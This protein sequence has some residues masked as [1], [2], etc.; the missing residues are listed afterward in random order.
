MKG[1][2]VLAAVLCAAIVF[3]SESFSID[4]RASEP[5]N[6]EFVMQTLEEEENLNAEEVSGEE[7]VEEPTIQPT[8]D[9]TPD[10]MEGT[11]ETVSPTPAAAPDN[12]E[13]PSPLETPD[14]IPVP[15]STT[16][17]AE[18]ETPS[19]LPTPEESVAPSATP[20]VTPEIAEQ[21]D[22]EF[23]RGSEDFLEVDQDGVLR[24]IDGK[25]IYGASVR[26]PKDAK[27]IPVGIFNEKTSVKYITFETGSELEEIEAGAFEGCGISSIE[28]P[29]GITTIADAT[30]KNSYLQSITFSGK[31]TCIGKEAFS[32][33]MLASVSA[34]EVTEVGDSAFSNC[35][36]L[37]SVQMPKLQKIGPRAFQYCTKLNSGMDWD[38]AL[39]EIGK[40]AFKGSGLVEL[41]LSSLGAE[42]IVL[43]ARAFENCIR[44][45]TVVL[46]KNLASVST[47]L[48]KG[49][50]ALKN[51]TFQK[52]GITSKV[53]VIGEDAFGDCS[54]LQRIIIPES[55]QKIQARAFEGCEALTEIIIR[56]T[57]PSEDSFSI[58][59]S[60][61]PNKSDNSKVTMQGYDGKVQE[62][63]E[64]RG[65]RFESLFEKY[66]VL[67]YRDDNASVVANKSK[68]AAGE[69]VLVTVTVKSG[70]S[71]TG[72]GVTVTSKVDMITA[73][74]V[75]SSG[76]KN[77]FRFTMPNG[78]ATIS[79]HTVETKNATSGA[80][81]FEFKAYNGSMALYDAEQKMLTFDKTG[82]ETALVVKLKEET[83]GSWLLN[84]KSNNTNVAT[85]SDKG[86]I[87][88]KGKGSAIITATLKNDSKKQISFKVTVKEDAVIRQLTLNLGKPYRAT[89]KTET[90][91][92][93]NGNEIT[94]PVVEYNKATVASEAKSFQV[95]VKAMEA[96]SSVDLQVNATWKSVDSKIASVSSAKTSDN[97][98]TVTVK[99]GMEGETMVTVSVQNKDVNKTECS[100]SFIIRVVDATPRLADSK[101]SVNKQSTEGTKIDI[102]PVYGYK[103]N[104]GSLLRVCKKVVSS[105]IVSYVPMNEFTVTED[106]G[107]FRIKTTSDMQLGAGKTVTYKGKTQLY[108]Q[109]EFDGTGDTF[110]IPIPEM[111]VVNKALNPSLKVTGKIN[112]FYNNKATVTEQGSVTITQNL[113]N[114][115]VSSYKLVS[116]KNYKTPG[117]EAEDSFAANFDVSKQA[118]GSALI[119]R[120]D[121]ESLVQNG[122]KP[123]TVG[124]LYIYYDGYSDPIK[125][126]ITVPTCNTKPSYELSMTTATASVYRQNQE[127]EIYLRDKK[128]KVKVELSGTTTLGFDFGSGGTT[129]ELFD[130]EALNSNIDQGNITVKVDG[131]P[132][133]GKAVITV[134]QE[135][136]G[137]ALKYT[138]NLN[139]TGTHPTVSLSS[140]KLVLNTLCPEE[141][142]EATVKVSSADAVFAGFDKD[143]LK[144]SGDKK[145]RADA[146]KLMAEMVFDNNSMCVSL[147]S[148]SVKAMTY[149]FK[150]MPKLNYIDSQT[151][152]YAK[153]VAF[154]VTV[155]GN[156][157]EMKLKKTSFTLNALYPGIETVESDYS[158][159]NIPD[160]VSYTMDMGDMKITPVKST[161]TTALNLKNCMELE[162]NDGKFT[163][164]LKEETPA[165]AFS[166]E[167][168]IDGLKVKIG[169]KEVTLKRFKIKVTGSTK[170]PSL[171]ISAKN[172]L[173]PVN[174]DSNIIYTAKVNNINS[175]IKAVK[176]WELKSDG[177]YYYDGSGEKPENRISE[178]FNIEM[179]GNQAI[180][181]AKDGAGLKAG[182][183]YRIKLAYVLESVPDKYQV[184]EKPFSIKSVQ[185]LPK[186]K[187]NK[188][189]AYLYAG[190]NRSKAVD[191]NITQTSVKE[192]EIVDVVF[193]KNTSSEVKKAYRVSYDSITGTATLK[194]VNPAS[195]VLNKKYTITL[196]TK[197]KNQLENSTGTTFKIDVTVRK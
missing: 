128:S 28:L 87:C 3:S 135:T 196:E 108:L 66:S 161:N 164:S 57:S 70:Y 75:S 104:N 59:Q 7:P 64:N 119:K 114:E 26:I 24:L 46:P 16:E 2:R 49:D 9:S 151:D 42:N 109:G 71:L 100:A 120:S 167:Y 92:D 69:E 146:E 155:K 81:T 132:R 12:T 126:K 122:N 32:G 89:L 190:Q 18:T 43:D 99:K 47:A 54:A 21:T 85:I 145:Y 86:V 118:D 142:A 62:Y 60:A 41:D 76:N 45:T 116:E 5:V 88:A 174:A 112:L 177:D 133:K 8:P 96:E 178:H 39:T 160:G 1:R 55:V 38:G 27:K 123:V 137:E 140:N 90:I 105:G 101:I 115:V 34:K 166:Y 74:L 187:T 37:T 180:V 193:A 159:L 168:Y 171:T 6:G 188:S 157:P 189:S 4:V 53:E 182:T 134:Q 169:E 150:I 162:F 95:S 172:T 17:P 30:F 56:N 185:T 129:E 106:D 191:I 139:T 141:K 58:S 68:A 179:K 117:T 152:Y 36:S 33:T 84:Y 144:F 195:V 77:V 136:W 121:R 127:Y 184:T 125:K 10:I 153:E 197:C 61:F 79:T 82:Q 183:T 181:T 107:E 22:L 23:V 65:Y 149:N 63:A 138:F 175:S 93:E 94:Y 20:S 170:N 91:Q 98:N 156:D 29:Q 44:L 13:E 35:S 19:V 103:I 102:V 154:S 147:P 14:G 51:V 15:D 52:D 192:A 110:I 97:K 143:T 186:I 48:F 25:E 11:E 40:E 78:E 80:M 163:I 158:I 131:K 67:F 50:T 194:L 113:T 72:E 173:N 124:Y 130:R 73:E 83:A 176:I 111:S 165:Q 148:D 31:V